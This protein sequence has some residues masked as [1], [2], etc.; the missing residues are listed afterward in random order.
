MTLVYSL[1]IFDR[2]CNVIYH[3]SWNKI[4]PDPKLVFGVVY[5]LGN[6]I[7]KLSKE[8]TSLSFS[9]SVYKLNYYASPSSLKIVLFTDLE[10]SKNI[11]LDIY[12]IYVEYCSK[13]GIEPSQSELFKSNLQKLIIK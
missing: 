4:S 5:S 11:L 8:Q 9:T 10:Y 1:F 13:S 3:Q 12:S 2:H 7:T 6:I